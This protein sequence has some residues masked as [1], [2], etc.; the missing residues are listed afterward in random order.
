MLLVIILVL[1][2]NDFLDIFKYKIRK[3]VE[4]FVFKIE[5]WMYDY[6]ECVYFF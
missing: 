2:I 1:G 6:V 3:I 5:G 4:F